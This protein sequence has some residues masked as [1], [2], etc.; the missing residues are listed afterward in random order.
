MA[1][2]KITVAAMPIGNVS[3]TIWRKLLNVILNG[4]RWEILKNNSFVYDA[5]KLYSYFS[6]LVTDARDANVPQMEEPRHLTLGLKLLHKP[7]GL[8]PK[9]GLHHNL[10]GPNL[11]Y[12][13]RYL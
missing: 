3:S 10:P 6:V 2:S 12:L 1:L 13:F 9:L 7:P 4:K 5:V 11:R 8:N